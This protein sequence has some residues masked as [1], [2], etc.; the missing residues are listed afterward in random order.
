MGERPAASDVWLGVLAQ[1]ATTSH[2]VARYGVIDP[3]ALARLPQCRNH[4]AACGK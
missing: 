2:A 3:T 4:N 1:P